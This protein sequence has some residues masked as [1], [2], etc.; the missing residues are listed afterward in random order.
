[1]DIFEVKNIIEGG[2]SL[3]DSCRIKMSTY[4]TIYY[5]SNATNCKLCTFEYLGQIFRNDD[6]NLIKNF[7]KILLRTNK[8]MF[9]THLTDITIVEKISEHYK[10][11]YCQEVPLGYG[12]GMQ[13]HCAFLINGDDPVYG[14]RVNEKN[15]YND[16]TKSFNSIYNQNVSLL[17]Q[18]IKKVSVDDTNVIEQFIIKASNEEINK[19]RSYKQPKRKKDLITKINNKV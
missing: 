2:Q 1:M 7:N 6:E 5:Y 4:S 11:I 17:K 18:T 19:L 16:I 8:K 10:L 3:G 12:T 15:K 14:K 9:F 13:Y